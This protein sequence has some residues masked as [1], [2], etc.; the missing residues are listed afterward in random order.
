M[1]VKVQLCWC[2][3]DKYAYRAS[4]GGGLRVSAPDAR[5]TRS[6]A[7]KM[8]DLLEIELGVDRRSVRFV[9]V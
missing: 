1:K 9:H 5:W 8:L 2:G 7:S 3:G 6:V 4:I